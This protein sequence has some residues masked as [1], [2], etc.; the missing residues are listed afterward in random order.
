[1]A[2]TRATQDFNQTVF[3]WL[4]PQYWT[5]AKQALAKDK[6]AII[7]AAATVDLNPRLI[8]ANLL[9][10]QLRLFFS[11]RELFKQFFQPLKIMANST[12]ISLGVMAIKPETAK[13]IEAH[14]RDASSP[15]YLGA[16][17][18]HLLDY[19]AGENVEE[20]RVKRLSSEADNHYWSYLYGAI[21]I[22][23]IMTQWEQAGFGI[24]ERPE[25]ICTLFNVGFAQSAPKSNP[26][27]GGSTVIV[28]AHSYSFGHL[29]NEFYFSGELLDDY[30]QL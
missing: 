21:Y 23:Q 3:A 13:Q 16:D 7:K 26:Q 27:V 10:E 8:V 30:P 28:N 1:L 22:K 11:Q 9:V 5:V 29:A 4:D 12:N 2:Q 6:S 14:L 19:T 25:I 17:R 24:G 20:A 15:F 18:E